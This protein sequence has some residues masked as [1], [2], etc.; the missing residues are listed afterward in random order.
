MEGNDSGGV[1]HKQRRW[2]KKYRTEVAASVS[3]IFSTFGAVS[4]QLPALQT[5]PLTKGI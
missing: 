2:V 3:S 5:S 1:G 4:P